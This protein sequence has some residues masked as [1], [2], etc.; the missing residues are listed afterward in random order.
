MI[1][2]V[3]GSYTL[4]VFI[5]YINVQNFCTS[6]VWKIVRKG[7]VHNSRSRDSK[8]FLAVAKGQC[9]SG[10]MRQG[11]GV[12]GPMPSL[13]ATG[14]DANNTLGRK[15]GSMLQ[16]RTLHMSVML[17]KEKVCPCPGS[18]GFACPLFSYLTSSSF[19]QPFSSEELRLFASNPS[20]LVSLVVTW[21]NWKMRPKMWAPHDGLLAKEGTIPIANINPMCL[22]ISSV[23]SSYSH[24]DLLVITPL[25]QI[26]PVLNTG[27]SLSEPLQLYKGYNAI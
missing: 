4:S 27:L 26:T 8:Q 17:Y 22:F 18:P 7:G 24:H 12:V 14:T 1:A 6:K 15:H 11:Q 19:S 9:K 25:F 10:Q 2:P 21:C 3:K 5:A 20:L 23:R 16:A 13:I